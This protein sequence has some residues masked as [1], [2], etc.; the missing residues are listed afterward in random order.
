MLHYL[1]VI[2]KTESKDKQPQFQEETRVLEISSN[3]IPQVPNP[4]NMEKKH[5]R[6][7]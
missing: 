7:K 3:K 4:Y 1:A 5:S 2:S 6:S